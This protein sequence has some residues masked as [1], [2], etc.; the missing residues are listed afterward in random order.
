[1]VPG[2]LLV[3]RRCEDTLD[4]FFPLRIPTEIVGGGRIEEVEEWLMLLGLER[5]I[6]IH[7]PLV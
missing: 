1:M 2:S 5:E 7:F 4:N 3:A 6:N